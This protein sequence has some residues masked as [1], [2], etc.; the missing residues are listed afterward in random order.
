MLQIMLAEAEP[1]G[2]DPAEHEPIKRFALDRL[3]QELS[4]LS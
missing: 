2:F 1:R 3:E 4:E